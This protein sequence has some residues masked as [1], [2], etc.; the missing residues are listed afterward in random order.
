MKTD[1][2]KPCPFCLAE[3]SRLIELWD[4]FDAGVIAHIH[5]E[6]C[7]ADGPSV[8]GEMGAAGT[9]M[10]A[11]AMW[12]ARAVAV[13]WAV[14]SAV[15]AEVRRRVPATVE[16]RRQAALERDAARYRFL[17]AVDHIPI[18]TEAARNPEV[19]DA[20]IDAAMGKARDAG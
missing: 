12:N 7:G 15:E 4:S 10:R 3:G 6:H 20:A 5:C 1:L 19:Y 9:I 14:D 13:A 16:Q 2:L 17:R 8:Y 11:R 18:S